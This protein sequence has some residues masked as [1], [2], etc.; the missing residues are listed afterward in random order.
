MDYGQFFENHTI[1]RNVLASVA[2][3]AGVLFLRWLLNRVLRVAYIKSPD[4]RRRWMV[5][6]RYVCFVLLAL[7]M[8]G[9][10]AE[11]LRAL[12]IS[13]IAFVVAFVLA[14]K[15]LIICLTGSFY[16]VS[17]RSFSI[18]DRITVSGVRGEVIDQTLLSTTI[19][20]IGPGLNIHQAT[21][22]SITLPNSM[23]LSAFVV[24]ES[25]TEDF[26]FHVFTVPIAAGED[27]QQAE[28]NLLNA[29][30]EICQPFVEQARKHISNLT[31]KEGLGTPSVD[32]R[33]TISLPD[34]GRI[35]LIVRVP[36]PA[37]QRGAVEQA[38]IRAYLT[39]QQS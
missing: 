15:E 35:D 34:P 39:R 6:I 5:Q 8:W 28:K 38:I 37:Q 25:F 1:A 9:I 33:V 32:P 31:V 4:L 14:T 18:G 23:F 27:W 12:A 11:E 7:A 22:R 29:A 17:S 13:V 24:N 19:L 2:V 16:K 3:I 20:E 26:T 36:V 10:W 30:Y 21:G